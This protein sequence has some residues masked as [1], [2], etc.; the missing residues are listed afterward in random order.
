LAVGKLRNPLQRFS[1]GSNHL[2]QHHFGKMPF[3]GGHRFGSSFLGTAFSEARIHAAILGRQ[4]K[5]ARSPAA[6]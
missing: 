3:F 1:F 2:P 6:R 4:T 5:K